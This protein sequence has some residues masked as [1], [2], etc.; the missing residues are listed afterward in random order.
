MHADDPRL[1]NRNT[2]LKHRQ[3]IK[4]LITIL[5]ILMLMSALL[6]W[7]ILRLNTP[8]ATEGR[9]LI[10]EV[11]PNSTAKLLV[12]KL[13]E[14]GYIDSKFIIE[15]Y[16]KYKG[17]A[18]QL[19]AGVYQIQ[20]GE[21]AINLVDRI[22]KGD[23]LIAAFRIIEGTNIY[24]VKQKLLQAPYLQYQPQDWTV[25]LNQYPSAE[26]LLLA[27][28]YYYNAGSD[29]KP[30]L[31]NANKKL[32]AVLN[33][34]WEKRSSVLPYKTPY[35]LLIAASII[36]KETSLP[37]ERRIISGI[38]VNRIK[39]RMPLQMDPTVIYALGPTFSG[40][41]GH[42]NLEFDSPYNTYLYRGL[43][44]TPIAM[45]GRD[46][47]E[48]AAHPK[49]SNYLYFVAKGDGSH[50]FSATYEEQKKAIARYMNKENQ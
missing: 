27:D 10:V 43:P 29:A 33:S 35:E 2:R 48:A 14:N 6:G 12:Q 24:Q 18:N 49:I 34:N 41:L 40:K 37:S 19:K 21:T 28:T 4:F 23:V 11:K 47:I 50:I 42:H 17:L 38:V 20:P 30:L 13:Y 15:N 39:K 5:I 32:L 1:N 46:A 7:F 8:M 3:L 45:V 16:I 36:E 31:V 22:V 44:P 25:I 9:S 26:G